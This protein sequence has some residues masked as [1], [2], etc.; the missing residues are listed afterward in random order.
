MTLGKRKLDQKRINKIFDFLKDEF[1]D[2]MQQAGMYT[3][4]VHCTISAFLLDILYKDDPDKQ[5]TAVVDTAASVCLAI[6]KRLNL[7]EYVDT[8]DVKINT[9]QNDGEQLH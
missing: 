8:V 4:I 6:I 2:D 9:V 5:L 1:G 3:Q 7:E